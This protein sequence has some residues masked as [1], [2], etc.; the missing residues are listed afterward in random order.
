MSGN[1]TWYLPT[2]ASPVITVLHL[3]TPIGDA[4]TI[5]EAIAIEDLHKSE[6]HHEA[7]HLLGQQ[8]QRVQSSRTNQRR[9]F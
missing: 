4:K 5:S 1:Y 9:R 6:T 2:K 3:G 8:R 7:H